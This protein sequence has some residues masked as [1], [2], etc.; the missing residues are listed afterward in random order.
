VNELSSYVFWPLRDGDVGVHRG[1]GNGL[2]PILLVFADE[3]SPGSVERLKH[4]YALKG[5][6]DPNWAVRPVA[7]TR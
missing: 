2:S 3:N 7:L 1:S 6:L 4:E 5:E